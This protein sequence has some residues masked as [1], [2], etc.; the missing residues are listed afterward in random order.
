MLIRSLVPHSL[1][2]SRQN[3]LTKIGSRSEIKLRGN[4]WSLHTRSMKSW[5]V[6]W[7]GSDPKWAPLGKWS[8][9]IIMIM[10]PFELGS[11]IMKSRAKSSQ[12]RDGGGIGWRSPVDF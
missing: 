7:G 1:K 5:A 2:G 10:A 4:P 8:T 11:L 12:S 6:K 3:L 9:T